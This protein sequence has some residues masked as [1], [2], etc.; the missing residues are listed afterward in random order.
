MVP[1]L[2]KKVVGLTA[3]LVERIKRP[4]D[5]SANHAA[6]KRA[7]KDLNTRHAAHLFLYVGNEASGAKKQNVVKRGKLR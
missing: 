5:G 3:I 6:A 4:V 1:V 2:R 7:K